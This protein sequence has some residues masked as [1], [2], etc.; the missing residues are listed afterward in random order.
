M[1]TTKLVDYLG[2][3]L[4]NGYKQWSCPDCT[5]MCNFEAMQWCHGAPC[6]FDQDKPES[7]GGAFALMLPM[8]PNVADDAAGVAK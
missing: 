5:A 7:N 6:P 3:P 2:D 4:P 8:L 1:T